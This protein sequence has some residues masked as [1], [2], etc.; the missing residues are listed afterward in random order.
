MKRRS[1]SRFS[2]VAATFRERV[3]ATLAR[4][5]ADVDAGTRR[6][7]RPARVPHG[8]R[9]RERAVF[10]VDHFLA[11]QTVQNVLGIRFA[12]RIF[13]PLWN[14][15]TWHASTSAGTRP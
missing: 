13:E 15:T 2:A 8:R 6:A 10:R 3:R 5:I 14:A 9:H 7:D 12:N 11:K 4:R 1:G